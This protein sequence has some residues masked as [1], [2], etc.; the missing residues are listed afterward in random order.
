ASHVSGGTSRGGPGGA[1]KG[2]WRPERSARRAARSA[3]RSADTD[4]VPGYPALQQRVRPDRGGREGGLRHH[5]P[6]L[7]TQPRAVHGAG[8]PPPVATSIARPARIQDNGDQAY[9]RRVGAALD[10]AD[11]GDAAR[12]LRGGCQPHRLVG[13]LGDTGGH[14]PGP[15]VDRSGAAPST[16]ECGS[17]SLLV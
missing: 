17:Q 9:H 14:H 8:R 6:L 1:G 5:V 7:G 15:V 2:R 4:R 16:P 11:P 12:D 13:N 3:P 10:C